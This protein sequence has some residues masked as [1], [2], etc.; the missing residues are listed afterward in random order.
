MSVL[1]SERY[2]S[3]S[4]EKYSNYQIDYSGLQHDCIANFESACIK[5]EA[6]WA[7]LFRERDGQI[8]ATFNNVQGLTTLAV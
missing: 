1:L 7:H 4:C 3:L 2:T 5:R 6:K 8:V